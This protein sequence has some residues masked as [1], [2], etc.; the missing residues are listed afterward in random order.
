MSS[1]AALATINTTLGACAGAVSAMFFASV[2]DWKTERVVSYDVCATMNGCLTG[3]VAITSGC[4]T[5][6]TWAAVV[7]GI[8]AGLF[9]VLGSKTLVRLRFDDAVDAVPVHMVGGAWGMIATGLLSSPQL[10]ANAY[11]ENSHAGWFY[12]WSEG[13][14]DF[15]LIGI[16]LLAVLFI[17]GWTGVTM[18]FWFGMMRYLGW[19]RIDELEEKVGM[20]VSRHKGPAY[21]FTGPTDETINQ[22]MERRSRH[23]VSIPDS[24]ENAKDPNPSDPSKEEN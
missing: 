22:L 17:F 14:G 18:G 5:V 4:G 11:G 2:W 21:E 10:I 8:F 3:L 15:T 12:A 1:V 6:E 7:I 9:Y 24:G 16:Q 20:D 13:S 23:K 19:F